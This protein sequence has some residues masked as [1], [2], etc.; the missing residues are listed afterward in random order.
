MARLYPNGPADVNHFRAAGVP[1]L[2]RE[3]LN[4]GL[5]LNV[6]TVAGFGLKRYTLEPGSATAV[7]WREGAERSP[8]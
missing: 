6:N 1:V 3:L 7:D 8:G 4:A 5:L 2:M